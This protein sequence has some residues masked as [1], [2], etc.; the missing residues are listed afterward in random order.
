MVK[1]ITS[2]EGGGRINHIADGWVV[3]VVA[4]LPECQIHVREVVLDRHREGLLGGLGSQS[5]HIV[6]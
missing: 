1:E 6:Q 2:R 3:S 4:V 5:L